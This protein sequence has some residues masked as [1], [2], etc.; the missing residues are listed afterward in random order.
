MGRRTVAAQPRLLSHR[1]HRGTHGR[2]RRTAR[3]GV[4]EWR[5]YRA[6]I[7]SARL[8]GRLHL[9]LWRRLRPRPGH[10]LAGRWA[11]KGAA[12]LAAEPDRHPRLARIEL[13]SSGP[14][15]RTAPGAYLERWGF[16]GIPASFLTVGFQTMVNAAAGF[17][18]MRWDLYTV[19][20]IPGCIAWA[21]STRV[22]A[23]SLYGPG[24]CRRG[25][26]SAPSLP[27]CLSRG[28][29]R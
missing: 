16:I 20:M 18:R 13:T 2:V 27:W 12:T 6:F 26:W 8:V 15:C 3:K 28:R 24:T 10:L 19:A 4:D 25:C 7:D 22:V 21:A 23:F 5:E 9:P 1:A 14:G 17:I 29:L 11:R